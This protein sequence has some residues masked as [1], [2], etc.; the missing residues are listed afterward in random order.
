MGQLQQGA[1]GA[2]QMGTQMAQAANTPAGRDVDPN[3]GQ[4]DV[5]TP[6]GQANPNN[7]APNDSAAGK[8]DEARKATNR[9]EGLQGGEQDATPEEQAS[10]EEALDALHQM[11]YEDEQRSNDIAGMLQ[12]EDKVGSVVKT[13]AMLM[14]QL[15]E[16]IDLDESVVAEITV[17]MVDRL[18]EMAETAHNI[19]YSEKEAQ[20]V[21]GAAWE[22][23]MALFGSDEPDPGQLEEMTQG[24]SEQD[25]KGY[26]EQY[27]GFLGD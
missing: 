4:V 16:G 25:L 5:T 11:L 2:Q 12:P 20:A 26:E 14:K 8:V 17:D 3:I 18:M 24:M 7:L 23:V 27:K 13:A 21:A 6:E 9:S 22:S 1:V 15:D 10:Y 19:T